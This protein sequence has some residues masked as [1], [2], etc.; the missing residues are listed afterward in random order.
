M[1]DIRALIRREMR[2]RTEFLTGKVLTQPTVI[3]FGPG[4]PGSETVWV[5]DVDIGSNRRLEDVPVKAN[6]RER[7][8]AGLGQAVLLHRNTAGR[9]EV[10]GP[11]DKAAGVT[12]IKRYTVDVA[13]PTDTANLGFTFRQETFIFYATA[14]PVSASAWN[15][16]IT[17]FPK[18][19]VLDG[20]GDPV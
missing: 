15:D 9:Y 2:S 10:T 4:G 3:E 1:S 16:G 20:D 13:T 6:N 19:T 14:G 12:A 17:P 7:G 8:Y 18:L 5:V 11:A